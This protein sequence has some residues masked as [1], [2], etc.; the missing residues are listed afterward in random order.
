VELRST[1]VGEM[2]GEEKRDEKK[3]TY[4]GTHGVASVVKKYKVRNWPNGEEGKSAWWGEVKPGRFIGRN[5][6]QRVGDGSLWE[7]G[8]PGAGYTEKR[9]PDLQSPQ[10]C[11]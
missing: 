8:V 7:G 10:A 1:I 9:F 3:A 5:Q 6:T 4:K 2:V 11:H